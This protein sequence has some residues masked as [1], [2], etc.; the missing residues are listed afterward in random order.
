M[1]RFAFAMLVL[2]PA[3]ASAQ[4]P[5]EPHKA[6]LKKLDFLAGKWKGPASATT[7]E[8]KKELTQTEIVEYRLGGTILIVEGIGRGKLPGKDEESVQYNAFAVI[9]YDAAAKKFKVKAYRMEGVAIEAD[10]TLIEKGIQWGFK[11][12]AGIEVRFTT[13]ITDKG[14]WHEVGE[15]SQDGK[16]W[17]K[18]M[19]MTLTKVKE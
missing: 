19:E 4:Q 16:T 14:E 6:E 17:T 2:F 12:Q 18:I 9:S 10:V 7:R 13:K 11:P 15:Y 1:N 3:F 5:S 8:G